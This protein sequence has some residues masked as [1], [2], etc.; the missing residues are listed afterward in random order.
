MTTHRRKPTEPAPAWPTAKPCIPH[1]SREEDLL[2][3]SE[4]CDYPKYP[5]RWFPEYPDI[6]E[7]LEIGRA[8]SPEPDLEAEA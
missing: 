1:P 2:E 5:D 3:L 6:S 8:R 7:L 4:P